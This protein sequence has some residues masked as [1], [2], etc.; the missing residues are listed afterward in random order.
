MNSNTWK[1]RLT[2]RFIAPAL[3][4]ATI[5]AFGTYE[6]LKPAAA[7]ASSVT[8]TSATPPLDDNSVG[9][10]L[11][12]DHAMEAVAARV[13]PATVNVAVTSKTKVNTSG[14][15]MPEGLQ[16]LPP[17]FRQFFGPGFGQRT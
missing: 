8:S 17:G 16:D 9:A 2:R 13:T 10:L 4:L 6:C 14:D 7:H 1:A 12:L 15:G 11:S 3:A 5:G